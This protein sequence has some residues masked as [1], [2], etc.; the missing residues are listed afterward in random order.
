MLFIERESAR[1][2]SRERERESIHNPAERKRERERERERAVAILAQVLHPCLGACTASL[3]R[4]GRQ[5]ID[6]GAV[7]PQGSSSV[8][9]QRCLS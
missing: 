6:L 1:H 7:T 8:F 2:R 9:L 3:H 5:R 4:G